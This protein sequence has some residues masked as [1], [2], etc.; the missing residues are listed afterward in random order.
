MLDTSPHGVKEYGGYFGFDEF[1]DS[2]V[3]FWLFVQAKDRS[4][5]FE[6]R[7]ALIQKLHWRFNEEGI[8]INYPVRTL[9]FPGGQGSED[10]LGRLLPGQEYSPPATTEDTGEGGGR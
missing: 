5:S 10:L 1:G 7:S 3:D 8:V 9:N 4:A 2:N 6:L